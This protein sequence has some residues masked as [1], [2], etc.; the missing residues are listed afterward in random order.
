MNSWLGWYL[1]FT[2]RNNSSWRNQRSRVWLR[3][4]QIHLDSRVDDVADNLLH[5][6]LKMKEQISLTYLSIFYLV[7]EVFS[8]AFRY[9]SCNPLFLSSFSL[10]FVNVMNIFWRYSS[11][12]Y[13]FFFL[14]NFSELLIF[15]IYFLPPSRTT[16]L[17]LTINRNSTS[18]Q[19]MSYVSVFL[20]IIMKE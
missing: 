7:I 19:Q 4:S 10:S 2:W 11:W 15:L 9:N 1:N 13:P 6:S 16:H 5:H 3:D 18:Y 17:M 12:K 14:Q 20:L 8:L